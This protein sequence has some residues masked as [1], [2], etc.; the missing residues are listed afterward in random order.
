MTIHAKLKAVYQ[1]L[2]NHSRRSYVVATRMPQ[3]STISWTFWIPL[4]HFYEKINK[5]FMHRLYLSGYFVHFPS[6]YNESYQDPKFYANLK[7]ETMVDRR[8]RRLLVSP[9]RDVVVPHYVWFVSLGWNANRNEYFVW[10]SA[11]GAPI[12]HYWELT[13]SHLP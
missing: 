8:L 7:L 2:N 13:E 5:I 1:K 10:N 12:G 6:V 3:T 11:S 4:L 9:R